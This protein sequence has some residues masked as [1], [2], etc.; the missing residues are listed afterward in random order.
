MVPSPAVLARAMVARPETAHPTTIEGSTM[1]DLRRLISA[2]VLTT[3]AGLAAGTPAAPAASPLR[4]LLGTQL[5]LFFRPIMSLPAS[6]NPVTGHGNP[7][8][9]T[10]SNVVAPVALPG[11]PM[12]TCTVKPGTRILVVGF[13]ADCS[14]VEK[15]PFYGGTHR[16]RAACV[17][18]FNHGIAGRATV[19]GRALP[20]AKVVSPDGRVTQQDK[21]PFTGHAGV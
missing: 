19:D 16:K 2:T 11:K 1:L 6:R 17:R 12:A 4:H 13:S 7:C 18:R 8:V 9:R 5:G 10:T 20:F 21:N 3:V 15:A 14:D